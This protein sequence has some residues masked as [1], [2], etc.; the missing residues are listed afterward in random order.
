MA[1]NLRSFLAIVE[2][3]R[4]RPALEADM[5][6]ALALRAHGV[7]LS[8]LMNGYK[9]GFGLTGARPDRVSEIRRGDGQVVS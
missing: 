4:V 9:R 5:G 2:V 7:A 6:L 1:G 3:V 8:R